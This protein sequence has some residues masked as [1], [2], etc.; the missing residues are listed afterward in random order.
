LWQNEAKNNN[1]FKYEDW[2]GVETAGRCLRMTPGSVVPDISLA[3]DL[4]AW[5]PRVQLRDGL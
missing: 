5:A 3:K 2:A 1:D 4:L